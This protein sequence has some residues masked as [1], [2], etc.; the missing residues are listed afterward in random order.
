MFGNEEV[1][2]EFFRTKR[3]IINE[4]VAYKRIINCGNFLELSNTG[5]VT[6]AVRSET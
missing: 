6:V 3:F 4:A 5:P 1:E 2:E